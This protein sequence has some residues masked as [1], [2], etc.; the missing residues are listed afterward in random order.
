MPPPTITP[1][2]KAPLAFVLLLTGL[3]M[4]GQMSTSMYLPS[5]PALTQDFRADPADAKLTMTVFLAAYA[6]AQLFF[7]SLSDRIGRRPAL[8]LGLTLYL[9]GTA[10]CALA[11]SIGALTIGRFIQG[12][13]ACSGPAI[14]R[15]IIR[16]RY[17]RHEA[18][19]ILAHIGMAMAVGPALGPIIGGQLQVMFGWRANF[20]ALVA[21]GLVIVIA[22]SIGLAETLREGDPDAMSPARLARNYGTL[23]RSRLYL[24]YMLVV[25][26]NFGGLFAYATGLP[27]VL[28]DMLGMSPAVF[29]TVFIFTVIGSVGGSVI[30]SRAASSVSTEHMTAIG[31]SVSFIGGALMLAF[32]LAD[33]IMPITI[34]GTMMIWMI[35][36]GIVLPNAFAGA[37]APFPMMAG[38][39]SA[40]MGFAQMGTAAL[41]SV[42]VAMLAERGGAIAMPTLICVMGAIS[43]AA[44]VVFIRMRPTAA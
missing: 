36:F 39:A 8:F 32:S 35:G 4:V 25:G 37:M 40:M 21:F 27:F 6:V 11:P 28:I 15:A 38:A 34:V 26:F 12:F 41:G 17:E 19:R 20:L 9:L 3:V 16:D 14:A 2:H 43:A 33:I 10:F 23:L 42:A 5:L 29:G 13:G 31:A 7:G 18:A 22:A 1:K 30:A 24:G 44:Y